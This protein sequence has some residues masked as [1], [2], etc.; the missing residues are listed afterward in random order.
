MRLPEAFLPTKD[1]MP[2]ALYTLEAYHC[3]VLQAKIAGRR[4]I[5]AG[6]SR[7]LDR[8]EGLAAPVRTR[9]K[10]M[11][12]EAIATNPA[13]NHAARMLDCSLQER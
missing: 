13:P 4:E 3:A 12:E 11:I 10:I 7:G 5:L 2:E 1:L 8:A 9:L 6:L